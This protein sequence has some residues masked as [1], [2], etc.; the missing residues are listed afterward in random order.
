MEIQTKLSFL[1]NKHHI[2]DIDALMKELEPEIIN[3]YER[4][5]VRV[6]K[7][8]YNSTLKL[9]QQT[10]ISCVISSLKEIY[11]ELEIEVSMLGSGYLS[12]SSRKF[13]GKI[14]FKGVSSEM[15]NFIYTNLNISTLLLTETFEGKSPTEKFK[16]INNVLKPQIE[17]VF[18]A[19]K[20]YDYFSF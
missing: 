18:G 8:I 15:R 11:P 20:A 2:E 9:E 3:F 16:K 14:T 13:S 1:D 7:L 10:K 17:R 4:F 5:S 12:P 6:D 19:I